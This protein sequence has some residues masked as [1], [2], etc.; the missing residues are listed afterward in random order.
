MFFCKHV[1]IFVGANKYQY[2]LQTVI[3]MVHIVPHLTSAAYDF[4]LLLVRLLL[5]ASAS[6]KPQIS[7]EYEI[8]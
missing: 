8:R 6:G 2:C 5:S 4:S 1:K 7:L 3:D